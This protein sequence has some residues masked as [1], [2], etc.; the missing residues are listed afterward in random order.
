[1]TDAKNYDVTDYWATP[2]EFTKRGGDCEDYAIAKFLTLRALNVPS[3]AM[4][5]VV[6]QDMNLKVGHAIAAVYVA[7]RILV[8]DNQIKPVVAAETVKHYM[9][10]FS[11]NEEGWWLH[12]PA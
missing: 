3:T 7:N 9:P 1:M 6:V 11:L 10:L 2:D 5:V 12:R 4:R 8:L